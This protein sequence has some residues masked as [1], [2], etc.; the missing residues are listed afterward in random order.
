MRD[1]TRKGLMVAQG[2]A[3]LVVGV[4]LLFLS[5][6]M[7]IDLFTL[8]GSILS[9][10]LITGSLL[11]IAIT[12]VLSSIGLDSRHAPHLR[13]LLVGSAIAAVA[14]VFVILYGPMTIRSACWLLAVYSLMLSIGKAH[15]AWHWFGTKQVKVA[16]GG[17]ACIALI[18]T[19]LLVTVA[20]VADDERNALIVIAAFALFSG[21]QMLLTMA[22]VHAQTPTPPSTRQ[23]V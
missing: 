18:F 16:I 21:L 2:I 5:A 15:L 7:T 20:R 11:F 8:L 17:L 22:Y 23:L 10:L 14:G 19:G 12:D 9:L 6:T 1:S 13:R 3:M 4:V